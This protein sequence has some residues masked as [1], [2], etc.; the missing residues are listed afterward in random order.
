LVG[1]F[2]FEMLCLIYIYM[3]V[4]VLPDPFRG[5]G[6]WTNSTEAPQSGHAPRFGPEVKSGRSSAKDNSPERLRC[7][8]IK[9]E[10]SQILQRVSAGAA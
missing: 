10:M 4:V 1:T 5:I 6:A 7:G 9:E 3:M 2:N 8:T